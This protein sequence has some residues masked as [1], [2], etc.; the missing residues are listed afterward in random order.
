M[1]HE[2]LMQKAEPI[3]FSGCF[4]LTYYGDG[5]GYCRVRYGKEHIYAHRL[6]YLLAV[7]PI[8]PGLCV[9]HHCDTPS[10]INPH[11]LFLGTHRENMMDMVKKGRNAKGGLFM[12]GRGSGLIGENHGCSKLSN[13]DVY[14]IR[15]S[16]LTNT[17]LAMMYGVDRRTVGEIKRRVI[18]KHL[19]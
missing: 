13:A 11:H 4:V 6:S 2:E 16:N 5:D 15:A 12:P 10:C 19:I 1:T 17:A 14:A 3:P 8:A 7:G 18:W 9:C